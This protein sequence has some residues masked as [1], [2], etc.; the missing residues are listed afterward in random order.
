MARTGNFKWRGSHNCHGGHWSK[1]ETHEA[2]NG[3]TLLENMD[4]LIPAPAAPGTTDNNGHWNPYYWNHRWEERE[5]VWHLELNGLPVVGCASSACWQS[6]LLACG[7]FFACPTRADGSS[8]DCSKPQMSFPTSG[9]KAGGETPGTM[10]SL[11]VWHAAKD[12]PTF[13]HGN[14]GP[15]CNT[16][17][18]SADQ[19]FI[20]VRIHNHR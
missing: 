19:N 4:G 9:E 6:D 8:P 18:L 14:S 3:T 2:L 10:K 7:D 11:R 5:L 1:E 20:A 15:S 17:Q 12:H 13:L 16:G